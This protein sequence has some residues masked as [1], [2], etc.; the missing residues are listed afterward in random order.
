MKKVHWGFS[1]LLLFELSDCPESFYS[2]FLWNFLRW[3]L[4]I[5]CC[6]QQQGLWERL[7]GATLAAWTVPSRE[8]PRRTCVPERE[9][10]KPSVSYGMNK[11]GEDGVGKI[12]WGLARLSTG[13]WPR[14][15]PFWE[16]VS[17]LLVSAL[18]KEARFCTVFV[19][20]WSCVKDTHLSY[21]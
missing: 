4:L 11:H 6:A 10:V 14:Q 21:C 12:S 17:S 20:E 15:T 18:F 8:L 7:H 5:R 13:G 9:E 2:T 3:T 19:N 16:T 1:Y